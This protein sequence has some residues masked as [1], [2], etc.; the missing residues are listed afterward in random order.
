MGDV[1]CKDMEIV[2]NIYGCDVLMLP[3]GGVYT[4]DAEGAK[5]YVD[6]VK[7][8]IVIPMHYMTESHKFTLNALDGFLSLFDAK[9][10]KR[11]NAD[12]LTLYDVPQNEQ[13][14]I[15]TLQKYSD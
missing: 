13:T 9:Q 3:V 5:W 2:K 10:I 7:P 8:K 11:L 12:S 14:Q 1:G 6:K 4:I 15:I